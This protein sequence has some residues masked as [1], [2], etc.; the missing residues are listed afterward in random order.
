MVKFYIETE[1]GC[2]IREA[3]SKEEAWADL[4]KEVGELAQSV[5]EATKEQV[6]WVE[7]MGGRTDE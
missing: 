6:S 5:C 7:A 4:K 2:G 1:L 3:D